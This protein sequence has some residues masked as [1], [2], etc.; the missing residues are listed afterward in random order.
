[1]ALTRSLLKAFV[2]R[3]ALGHGNERVAVAVLTGTFLFALNER[4][5]H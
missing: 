4:T 5:G 3:Q 2:Q 1:M